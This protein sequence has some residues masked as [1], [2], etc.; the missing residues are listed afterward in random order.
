MLLYLVVVRQSGLRCAG[1]AAATPPTGLFPGALL[2]HK[3]LTL[4]WGLEDACLPAGAVALPCHLSEEGISVVP[5]HSASSFS[6][7]SQRHAGIS[8]EPSECVASYSERGLISVTHSPPNFS[9]ISCIY[10]HPSCWH[11][12]GCAHKAKSLPCCWL[13]SAI[14]AGFIHS[15][16]KLRAGVFS[17]LLFAVGIPY[18]SAS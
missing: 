11:G 14:A 4:P 9:V 12:A 16:S 18:T 17:S 15:H 3:A 2:S 6:H 7:L 10:P 13:I 1:Q 8:L 5:K